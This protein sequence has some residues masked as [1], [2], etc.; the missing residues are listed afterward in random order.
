[1]SR[2][3]LL[4]ADG[5]EEV[6]ALAV[7]DI[8]RRANVSVDMVS[9]KQEM[10]VVSS[11]KIAMRADKTFE[12]MDHYEMVVL[13]GGLPGAATLRGDE[14]VN[15]LL[16]SYQA[17]G[18]KIAAICAG[19]MALGTSGV[20]KGKHVTSYPDE[21]TK[22]FLKEGLYEEQ[23]VVV[24]GNIITSRGPATAF[25]FAYALLRE[26]GVEPTELKQKMLYK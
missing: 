16:K 11:R 1:M 5:F 20:I 4:L 13:P 22:S 25:A 8:L 24:D 12:D 6:E 2:V 21:T 7:V 15:T 26:L 9:I 19:P 3:A 14:R 17:K 10:V 23:D 18:K